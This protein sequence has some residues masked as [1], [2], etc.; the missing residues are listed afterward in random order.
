[1]KKYKKIDGFTEKDLLQFGYGHIEAA[2]AL[3]KD[4]PVFLDSAGY[5]AHLGTEV[6]LKAM[7]F[8]A[9]GEFKN[10][11][12]LYT[13]YDELKQQNR[14]FEIDQTNVDFL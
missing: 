10:C 12:N 6:V 1:M 13:L 14:A 2:I 5:L 7:H 9:F 3:F 8:F 4:E 11:H